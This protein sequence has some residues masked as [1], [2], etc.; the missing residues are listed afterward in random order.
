M[1]CPDTGKNNTGIIKGIFDNFIVQPTARFV[2]AVFGISG[3]SIGSE[4]V[5]I[6]DFGHLGVRTMPSRYGVNP[7]TG[8]KIV[9]P[10]HQKFISGHP[11]RCVGLKRNTAKRQNSRW[12]DKDFIR[13]VLRI[14][15]LRNSKKCKCFDK[16]DYI[17]KNNRTT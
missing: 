14:I 3:E 6:P 9:F 8:E 2:K 1:V 4:D 11:T 15:V 10:S 16:N 12:Y 7:A 17:C 13:L 5:N